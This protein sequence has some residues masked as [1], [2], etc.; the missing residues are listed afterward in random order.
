M[1]LVAHVKPIAVT[2]IGMI[3]AQGNNAADSWRGIR[4]GAEVLKPWDEPLPAALRDIKV[5][6]CTN[7]ARP[8]DLPPR[9]WTRLSRT[10]QLACISTDE[11]LE[12]AGLSRRQLASDPPIGCFVATT[13]CGMDLSERYYQQYRV[14]ADAADINLMRRMQPYEVLSLLSR[15]HRFAGPGYMNL[16]TCVGSAMAIGAACDA[17]RAGRCELAV[18]GGTEALCQLLI[19]GFNSL[20]LVSPDGCRPFDR[21]RPGITVGEGSAMLMLE[22]IHSARRRGKSPIAYITG[23]S[24]TCDAFHITKPE[25]DGSAAAQAMR[26]ALHEAGLASS[27]VDYINAHGTG[28][29]D[30]DVT[31]A[32]AIAKVFDSKS[33]VP[34]VSSTKRLTGHTFGAAGAI[35]AAICILALRHGVLPPNAGSVDPDPQCPLPLVLSATAKPLATAL[36]CNLAFGGNNTALVFCRDLPT[37]TEAIA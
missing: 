1:K 7:L 34:P 16:T 26:E 4:A 11:A 33:G 32:A 35:E 36:S 13:V 10:Q 23:F 15:R 25:P 21:N 9:L 2:G 37:V 28:T 18:A 12:S 6:A 29:H 24:A 20:R 5:A 30:N 17:I 3:T 14:N 22:S 31:E 27:D 8:V 19:S